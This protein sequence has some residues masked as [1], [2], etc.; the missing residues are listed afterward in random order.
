MGKG[1]QRAPLG[2]LC[3]LSLATKRIR[4]GVSVRRSDK[5]PPGSHKVASEL[6]VR[7]VT[8]LSALPNVSEASTKPAVPFPNEE[9]LDR[10]AAAAPPMTG[11]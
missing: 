5:P 6:A 2:V 8:T 10:L 1:S 9:D 3:R 11:A 4:M 7:Y